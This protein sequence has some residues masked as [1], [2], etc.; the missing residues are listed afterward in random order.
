MNVAI[1]YKWALNPE[2]A[3]VKDDASVTW[4]RPKLAASDDDAAAIACARSLAQATDGEMTAVTIGDGDATWALARGASRAVCIDDYRPC[5]DDTR[6]AQALAQAVRAAGDFD[7]IVM[8]DM[9]LHA[10]VAGALA[11]ELGIPAVLGADD[12][13]PD[14]DGPD[15]IRVRR[16]SPDA[17]ETFRVHTPALVAVAAV[18]TEVDVPGIKQQLAA[19]KLPVDHKTTDQVADLKPDVVAEQGTRL[20]VQRI[21]TTFEGTV[22]QQVAQL[23][24]ALRNDQALAS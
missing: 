3:I 7:V 2:D 15:A 19:K 21:A 10:G 18:R 24:E 8:G 13:E 12:I 6:T 1:I 22:E 5:D 20:P 4:R 14:P 23:L 16:Q 9:Q 17:I 11:A